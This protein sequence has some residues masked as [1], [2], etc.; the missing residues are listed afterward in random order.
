MLA[1]RARA[2][3]RERVSG[4]LGV[5]GGAHALEQITIAAA[6]AQKTPPRKSQM[7]ELRRVELL[8]VA[9]ELEGAE[10]VR[11]L[12]GIEVV[13]NGVKEGHELALVVAGIPASQRH[14]EPVADGVRPCAFRITADPQSAP[15]VLT[16]SLP[17]RRAVV[18]VLT[19]LRSLARRR[20][21]LYVFES[22]S[23]H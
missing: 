23:A 8:R 20:I 21:R 5:N 22:C 13:E 2:T 7:P 6:G 12:L 14:S 10:A 15:L 3:R 9:V 4:S 11:V 18:E 16:D 19:R 17:Q 1:R